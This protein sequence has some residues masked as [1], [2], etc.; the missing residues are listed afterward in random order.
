M[1]PVTRE[2]HAFAPILDEGFCMSLYY[3]ELGSEVGK[4]TSRAA[5]F[6]GT[7][8]VIHQHAQLPLP[9]PHHVTAGGTRACSAQKQN[10]FAALSWESALGTLACYIYKAST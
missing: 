6:L 8:R 3:R 10:T 1:R 9:R 4:T 2:V 5:A 7:R